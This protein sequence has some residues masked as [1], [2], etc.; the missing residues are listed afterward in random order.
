[1]CAGSGHFEGGEMKGREAL[2]LVKIR[3]NPYHPPRPNYL[4]PASTTEFY[5]KLKDKY[6][7][8]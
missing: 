7:D 2:S 4:F 3:N 6:I 5:Y 1:M 8:E